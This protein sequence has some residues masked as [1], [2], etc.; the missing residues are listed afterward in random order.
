MD[1]NDITNNVNKLIINSW[2]KN[3]AHVPQDIYL[4]DNS[5]LENIV[6]GLDEK[7][8]NF[9]NVIEVCKKAQILDFIN[10]LPLNFET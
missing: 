10:S 6:F 8:I 7:N 9:N 1:N 2:Q 4:S 5:I 3:I